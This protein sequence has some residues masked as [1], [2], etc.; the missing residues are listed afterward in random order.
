MFDLNAL[1]AAFPSLADVQPIGDPSGQKLVFRATRS[2]QAVCLKI[3][4]PTGDA[5]ARAERELEAVARLKSD[6]V[7]KLIDRGDVNLGGVRHIFIIEEF[8]AG[9]T[10]RVH[11]RLQLVQPVP[12]VLDLVDRLLRACLDFEKASL[13]HRDIKPENLILDD[14]GKVWVLD[15]GIVRFLDMKSLTA[16]S[17]RIGPCTPGYGAPEQLRNQKTEIN[18]RAD[19]FSVGVV[20]YESLAGGNPYLQGKRH[21]LEVIDH[22]LKRDLPPLVVLADRDGKLADFISAMT[23]RFASRRPRTASD[24]AK[25]LADVRAHLQV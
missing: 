22:A 2:G 10:Y 21:A 14:N 3:I 8:V 19:L 6:F 12:A 17:D 15:F 13:V 5:G 4:Q 16:S 9:K 25:W 20:A 7:P 11:L 18:G 23:A 24:A 1:K